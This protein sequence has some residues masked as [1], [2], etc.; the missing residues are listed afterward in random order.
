MLILVDL[1]TDILCMKISSKYFNNLT[2]KS[3]VYTSYYPE[4]RGEINNLVK[5]EKESQRKVCESEFL[6]TSI[7]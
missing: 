4:E 5:R 3:K 6:E 1:L 7:F 2:N